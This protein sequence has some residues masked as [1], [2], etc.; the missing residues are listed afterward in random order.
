MLSIYYH[1]SNPV[2][3]RKGAHIGFSKT[4]KRMKYLSMISAGMIPN[5]NQRK[6]ERV[7]QKLNFHIPLI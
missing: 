5:W 1:S 4:K 6:K 7:K 3:Q 2:A